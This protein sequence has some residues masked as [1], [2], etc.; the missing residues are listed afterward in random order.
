MQC[1]EHLRQWLVMANDCPICALHYERVEG[2]WLGA[3][4]L[5]LIFTETIF[6]LALV[7]QMVIW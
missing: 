6:V 2:Y 5:N 4:A 3:V 1:Y 7:A